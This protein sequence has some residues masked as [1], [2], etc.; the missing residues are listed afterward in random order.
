MRA[1]DPDSGENAE[2]RYTLTETHGGKF[3]LNT[4]TREVVVKRLD[5]TD[6][7]TEVILKVIAQDKGSHMVTFI[8]SILSLT[9]GDV[10]KGRK[11]SS[12]FPHTA[13]VLGL[14]CNMD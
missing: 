1:I 5:K 13:M 8:I 10:V 12:Q 2:L 6:H 4:Y 11:H 7:N 9:S 3:A 14:I